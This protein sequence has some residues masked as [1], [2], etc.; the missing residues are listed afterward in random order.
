MSLRIKIKLHC[1]AKIGPNF[2][3]RDLP[4]IIARIKVP[5]YEIES[6][7]ACLM[8]GNYDIKDN[9]KRNMPFLV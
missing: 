6:N 9:D 8:V 7:L 1:A 3:P 5:A 4:R 2:V